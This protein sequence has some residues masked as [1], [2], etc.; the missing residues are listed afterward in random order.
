MMW[1]ISGD[2]V[3]FRKLEWDGVVKN[4]KRMMI[5]RL[6]YHMYIHYRQF[7]YGLDADLI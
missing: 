5:R 4:V 2:F 6:S 3:W 1:F 7:R